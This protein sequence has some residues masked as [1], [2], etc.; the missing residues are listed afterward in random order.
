MFFTYYIKTM[1]F[2][3]KRT[4]NGIKFILPSLPPRP[5]SQQ[6]LKRPP[7]YDIPIR[8]PQT[9]GLVPILTPLD[10]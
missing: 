9:V 7:P 10:R 5:V 2:V 1:T 4:N 3:D 6:I 8:R